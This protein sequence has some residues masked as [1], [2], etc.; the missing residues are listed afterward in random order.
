VAFCAFLSAE[1]FN[2]KPMIFSEGG[3]E[4]ETDPSQ[5]EI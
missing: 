2:A 4:F 5:T 1:P 3:I